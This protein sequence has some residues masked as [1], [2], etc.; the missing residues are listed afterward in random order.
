MMKNHKKKMSL[1]KFREKVLT[2]LSGA[3]LLISIAT[4]LIDG[5]TNLQLVTYILFGTLGV[6][7]IVWIIDYV[8]SNEE[9]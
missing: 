1:E 3:L 6:D 7:F 2:P 5:F 4:M 9:Q 8:T